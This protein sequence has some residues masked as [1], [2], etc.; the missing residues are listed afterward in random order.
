MGDGMVAPFLFTL[1]SGTT[2]CFMYVKICTKSI[3]PLA[4]LKPDRS[5]L[6]LLS[7]RIVCNFSNKGYAS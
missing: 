2:L 1:V 5:T 4:L 6:E 3:Q 7:L